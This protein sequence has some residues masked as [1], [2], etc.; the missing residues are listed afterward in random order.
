MTDTER[1]SGRRRWLLILLGAA[2]IV[3]VVTDMEIVEAYAA[4]GHAWV[5]LLGALAGIV[6]LLG[7]LIFGWTFT[8]A[9]L[10]PAS[11]AILEDELVAANRKSAFSIAYAVQILVTVALFIATWFA[12]L[13]AK[14]A[15][16]FI[17]VT[18]IVTPMFTFAWL[19]GRGG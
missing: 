16:T 17:L 11:Q 12:E 15:I 18:G 2:F 14:D 9:K 5:S 6:W 7:M 19:E 4:N 13:N 1:L 8:R 10:D 3:W